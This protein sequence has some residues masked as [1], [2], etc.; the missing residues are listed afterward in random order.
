MPS[1][2]MRRPTGPDPP[3][4]RRKSPPPRPFSP[5]AVSTD[6]AEFPSAGRS[7]RRRGRVPSP[8]RRRDAGPARAPGRRL[9]WR[10]G[11]GRCR[12]GSASGP[13]GVGGDG[14][15][16][17]LPR[18]RLDGDNLAVGTRP[19]RAFRSPGAPAAPIDP[20][21]RP[22]TRW[23]K[24]TGG[25]WPCGRRHRAIARHGR[26]SADVLDL[27]DS[28]G[29]ASRSGGR[30]GMPGRGGSS[31]ATAVGL[32]RERREP[33]PDRQGPEAIG[34]AAPRPGRLS[35]GPRTGGRGRTPPGSTRDLRRSLG[36]PPLSA[37][38]RGPGGGVIGRDPRVT[39]TGDPRVVGRPPPRAA[40][41]AAARQL[42]SRGAR[43]PTG[44][45]TSCSRMSGRACRPEPRPE[46]LAARAEAWPSESQGRRGQSLSA[47][48]SDGRGRR[49]RR[50]G[51]SPCSS[52]RHARLVG[53]CVPSC[54]EAAKGPDPTMMSP[55]KAIDAQSSTASADRPARIGPGSSPLLTIDA[56]PPPCRGPP[57]VEPPAVSP[58]ESEV[59]PATGSRRRWSP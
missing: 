16:R 52:P 2:R 29:R 6:R 33:H 15:R 57:D 45:S 24:S 31:R 41:L 7:W 27:L 47:G 32:S 59:G 22:E 23:W 43:T 20:S 11:N 40:R 49:H 36:R 39:A 48:H 14:R 42:A 38:A 51:G 17:G 56:N 10:R 30:S 25:P 37:P 19:A 13:A 55:G 12:P 28:A 1:R 34:Q 54:V 26:R 21:T 18:P 35:A 9:P 5:P 4:P 44:R 50:V 46:H 3:G 53:G 58:P 8:S